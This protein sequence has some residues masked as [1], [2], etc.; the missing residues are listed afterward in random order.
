M[1][2]KDLDEEEEIKSDNG[3]SEISGFKSE[4]VAAEVEYD[5]I[6]KHTST[7]FIDE[8]KSSPNSSVFEEARLLPSVIIDMV[9]NPTSNIRRSLTGFS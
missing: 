5:K 4:S 2:K 9:N 1:P 8:D 7:V 3:K 6:I